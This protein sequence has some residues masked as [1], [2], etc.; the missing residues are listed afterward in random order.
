M[1]ELIL[2]H[3]NQFERPTQLFCLTKLIRFYSYLTYNNGN[4]CLICK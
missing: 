4:F 2:K 1:F 3:I